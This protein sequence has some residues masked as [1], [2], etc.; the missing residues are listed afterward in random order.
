MS[1]IDHGYNT[2]DVGALWPIKPSKTFFQKDPSR[3][4][5]SMDDHFS[6]ASHVAQSNLDLGHFEAKHFYYTLSHIN[7]LSST[8]LIISKQTDGT[9]TLLDKA[10]ASYFNLVKLLVKTIWPATQPR[11]P[12]LLLLSCTFENP[13]HCSISSVQVVWHW[14]GWLYIAVV[15]KSCTCLPDVKR[16]PQHEGPSLNVDIWWDFYDNNQVDTVSCYSCSTGSYWAV[17]EVWKNTMSCRGTD[18]IRSLMWKGVWANGWYQLLIKWLP[19]RISQRSELVQ[20]I[21]LIV[22]DWT[23][24]AWSMWAC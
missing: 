5:Q 21:H 17:F 9:L 19:S 2:T 4:W 16:N 7:I 13:V 22:S 14:C 1:D 11:D 12:T 18:V 24:V 8:L 20:V 6:C 23:F 10:K 15:L 3:L